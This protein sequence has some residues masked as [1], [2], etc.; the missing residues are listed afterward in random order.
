M[1]LKQIILPLALSGVFAFTACDEADTNSDMPRFSGFDYEKPVVAGDSLTI[2]AKQSQLGKL[3]YTTTYDWVCLYD[4]TNEE[5]G[6]SGQKDTLVHVE[7]KLNYGGDPSDPQFKFL[8]PQNAYNLYIIFTADYAYAGQGPNR[9]DGS[10]GGEGT[11]GNGYIR[12]V[13]SN[14]LFGRTK[15][16]LTIRNIR[17]K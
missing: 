16:Q 17:H 8:V 10:T 15:G 5:E 4:W 9:Y 1:K 3:I 11:A 2:V 12:P 13:T 14:N 7:K 6:T